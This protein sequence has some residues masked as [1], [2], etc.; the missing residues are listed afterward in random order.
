MLLVTLVR[1][2]DL[3]LNSEI[4]TIDK[5][6]VHDETPSAC[7]D[8]YPCPLTDPDPDISDHAVRDKTMLVTLPSP[9][10][11]IPRELDFEALRDVISH[12]RNARM[13]ASSHTGQA[14]PA[15]F[16]NN[17]PQSFLGHS[18][19]PSSVPQGSSD[20]DGLSNQS[21]S[22][23]QA[24][25]GAAAS[26]ALSQM[27]Q[28]HPEAASASERVVMS[29][30][31]DQAGSGTQDG[32]A[33]AAS[34]VLETTCSDLEPTWNRTTETDIAAEPQINP[35]ISGTESGLNREASEQGTTK[36]LVPAMS[37]SNAKSA[38]NTVTSR[39]YSSRGGARPVPGR[40]PYGIS[41]LVAMD[42]ML[43]SGSLWP[44]AQAS[45]NST[46]GLGSQLLNSSVANTFTRSGLRSLLPSSS[47]AW[48]N[49]AQGTAANMW[50]IQPGVGLGQVHRTPFIQ[51]YAWH[52]NPTFHGNGHPPPRG[53]Y[54][55][56]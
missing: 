18:D 4:H 39:N 35:N 7:T 48:N 27:E 34:G 32:M 9:T 41:T 20:N 40:S 36:N 24:S 42:R 8:P 16:S 31:Q 46:M 33:E 2:E 15:S 22:S 17:A 52:G 26:Q 14:S 44:A 50:G 23:F 55:G 5:T 12:F 51:S 25:Q 45:P 38:D 53:G 13:Q 37:S 30:A 11:G 54:G 1:E 56:W 43:Q 3:G 6:S 49:F 28:I 19:G 29:Q 21:A 10:S 47:V